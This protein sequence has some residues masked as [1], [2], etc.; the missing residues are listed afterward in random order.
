MESFGR[1]IAKYRKVAKMSQH[2][3]AS[4]LKNYGFSVGNTAIST[5]EKDM[6]SP[7]AMQFLAVCKILNITNIYNEF[8]GYNPA[9]PLAK[10]N[11]E[12]KEKALEYIELLE[13]SGKYIKEE[14]T[15]I[16]FSREI[17]LFDLPVSAGL[18][19]FLDSEEYEMIEVGAEV[20]AVAQ[21]GVRIKGDSMEPRFIDGQ[22]VF[23]QPTEQIENGEIGIFYLNGNAYCKKLQ[24]N[25]D[26]NFLIS[27]NK[28]YSPIQIL[29]HD[30]FV[31]FG[32]VVG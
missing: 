14:A 1:I 6:N 28:E 4:E 9:D 2:E 29:K 31:T 13:N 10:L 7:S 21:F 5:W 23:I 20:P 26:G 32:R 24:A 3:L 19:E 8:I 11:S 30:S 18:G 22:I 27:L 17:K 15:V 16:P 25:K 12:G